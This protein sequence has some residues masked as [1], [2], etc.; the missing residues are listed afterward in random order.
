MS[1]AVL[2]YWSIIR[3]A[4]GAASI[5]G[6]KRENSEEPMNLAIRVSHT[7]PVSSTAVL[8][9][10][11]LHV[12]RLSLFLAFQFYPL[13]LSPR[14]RQIFCLVKRIPGRLSLASSWSRRRLEKASINSHNVV[15]T[16]RFLPLSC[17][18][19]VNLS[20]FLMFAFS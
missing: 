16:Y 9:L 3:Q 13:S 20:P 18:L 12:S 19:V 14:S 15:T 17:F 6:S 1:T 10:S 7:F 8:S 5:W 4:T 2:T 11:W